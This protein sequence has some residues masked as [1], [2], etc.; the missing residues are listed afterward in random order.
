[1]PNLKGDCKFYSLLLRHA[2]KIEL[3]Y[4]FELDSTSVCQSTIGVIKIMEVIYEIECKYCKNKLKISDSEMK[5]VQT[6]H[7]GRTYMYFRCP[8]CVRICHC[9]KEKVNNNI[10]FCD[11]TLLGNK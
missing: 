3:C 11:M 1:M 6:F 4:P 10:K 8:E 5:L 9:F 7:D 2:D